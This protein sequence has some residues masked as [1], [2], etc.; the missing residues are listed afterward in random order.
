MQNDRFSG[1]R[2]LDIVRS[3]CAAANE[4]DSG[5]GN[6]SVSWTDSMPDLELL[7]DVAEED[8]ESADVLERYTSD[9][10]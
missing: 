9:A 5:A 10:H 4:D 7:E 6:P 3:V 1:Q 2:M 8:F